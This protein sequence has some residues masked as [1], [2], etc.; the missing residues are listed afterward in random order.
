MEFCVRRQPRNLKVGQNVDSESNSST[1]ESNGYLDEQKHQDEYNNYHTMFCHFNFLN[2]KSISIPHQPGELGISISSGSPLSLLRCCSSSQRA[3][4][5]GF[6]P[7]VSGKQTNA[8][9]RACTVIKKYNSRMD[10]NFQDNSG[11]VKHTS[12][13]TNIL[14]SIYF[15]VLFDKRQ[16]KNT[17]I[18]TFAVH[19]F[20][21][22][23]AAHKVLQ[24]NYFAN[25]ASVST[26]AC[27]SYAFNFK[28]FVISFCAS[29]CSGRVSAS[30]VKDTTAPKQAHVQIFYKTFIKF[31]NIQGLVS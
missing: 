13:A 10:I 14:R 29:A 28:M 9:H 19:S 30:L 23:A 7:T 27:R 25:E 18:I 3:F 22:F 12:V 21:A 6:A 2:V 1:I 26:F 4:N 8:K 24:K 5:P 16:S 15:R 20:A 17:F 31:Q 11:A